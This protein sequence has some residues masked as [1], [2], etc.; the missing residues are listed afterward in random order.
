MKFWRIVDCF[1]SKQ[2]IG[3][4]KRCLVYYL[5]KTHTFL[6][7]LFFGIY[8]RVT[9]YKDEKGIYK[10]YLGSDYNIYDNKKYSLLI[11]NHVSWTV[12]LSKLLT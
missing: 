2:K 4:V 8:Y 11:S 7:L 9:P 12:S 6:I 3:N 5:C 10:K 1:G